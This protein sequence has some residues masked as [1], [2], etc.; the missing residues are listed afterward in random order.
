LPTRPFKLWFNSASGISEKHKKHMLAVEKN[1]ADHVK[2]GAGK[3][4]A[5]FTSGSFMDIDLG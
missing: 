5:K 2:N 3:V 4:R 1:V